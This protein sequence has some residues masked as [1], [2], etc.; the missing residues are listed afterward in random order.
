MRKPR[1]PGRRFFTREMAE[2]LKA[3][4]RKAGLTQNEV[5]QRMG[6]SYQGGKAFVSLLERGDVADPHLSTLCLYLKAPRKTGA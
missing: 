4:R 1:G 6:L 5:A 3:L 2:R